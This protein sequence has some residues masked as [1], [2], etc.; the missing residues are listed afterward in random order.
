MLTFESMKKR[1]SST[2]IGAQ[3]REMSEMVMNETF[4]NDTGY[5]KGKLY[6]ANM[7]VIDE[8]E[9]KF[10]KVK[11]YTMSKDQVEYHVQFRPGV[12][13]EID[14]PSAD[15]NSYINK[16]YRF[17][18][19]ID[20]YD[21]DT[22]QYDKWLIVG[23]D[24]AE[25]DKYLVLKC[26]WTFEWIDHSGTYHS[27]LGCVRD[28]NSYNSGVWS[29]GFTTSVENQSMFIVPMN[30]STI[31]LDYNIRIMITDNFLYPKVYEVTKVTDTLPAG[32]IK[33]VLKQ[34]H[35]NQHTD[36]CGVDKEHIFFDDDKIHMVADF[37]KSKIEPINDS[38]EHEFCKHDEEI[39]L[40]NF[41]V[42][43]TWKLSEVNEFLYVNGQPQTIEA[44]CGLNDAICKWHI[45]VD[46][47][48]YTNKKNELSGYLDINEN[49]N[50]FTITAIN[51]VMANYIIKIGAGSEKNIYY[52]DFVEME[53]RI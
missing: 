31:T 6:D 26:N 48:D 1:S 20:I 21:D 18:Y 7:K 44:N 3:L 23:K 5:R 11:T 24:T 50:T 51:K 37:Y 13:P 34:V 15:Y 33:T 16:K 2:H 14:Y 22:R 4:S 46:N 43:E 39:E 27:C 41:K 53:V 25:F 49:N 45:F 36:L 40:D 28:R 42:D 10:Q 47:E 52:D 32:C 9:F 38:Y 35:H 17:N 19:Y 29:D 12:N 8:L 30:E